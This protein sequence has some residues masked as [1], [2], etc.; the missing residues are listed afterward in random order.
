MSLMSQSLLKT[1]IFLSVYVCT[2]NSTRN[3]QL[4]RTSISTGAKWVVSICPGSVEFSVYR[5]NGEQVNEARCKDQDVHLFRDMRNVRKCCSI[6]R[7]NLDAHLS[8]VFQI[9]GYEAIDP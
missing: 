9:F 5:H 6:D 1:Y 7:D 8:K 3:K 4:Y 2:A